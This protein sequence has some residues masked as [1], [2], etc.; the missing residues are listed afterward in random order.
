MGEKR[1]QI[2][3]I[4]HARCTTT[5]FG[6]HWRTMVTM[7]HKTPLTWM[8]QF[9][10]LRLWRP[11]LSVISAAF[12]AFGRSCLFAK[13]NRTWKQLMRREDKISNVT[14]EGYLPPPSVRPLQAFASI[15]PLPPLLFPCKKKKIAPNIMC[16]KMWAPVIA[17]NDEDKSLGVLEVV[18]PQRPDLVLPIY[19]LGNALLPKTNF[20]IS[21]LTW[22]P[23]SQ[24]VKLMFLYSTVS[25][26]KPE[27]LKKTLCLEKQQNWHTVYN[28]KGLHCSIL[29]NG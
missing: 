20:S 18:A 9:L 5:H 29:A 26:L 27:Q 8:Y 16:H 25:T 22:P 7:I 28:N 23:T 14:L 3:P 2:L 6:L 15:R 17:V 21:K 19:Q 12:M 11:S 4:P 24:T 13:I 10:F 1:S